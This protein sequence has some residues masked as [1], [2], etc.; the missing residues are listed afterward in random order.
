MEKKDKMDFKPWSAV[1]FSEILEAI[2]N[3]NEIDNGLRKRLVNLLATYYGAEQEEFEEGELSGYVDFE[4][5]FVDVLRKTIR[6]ISADRY[7]ELR[8]K[9]KNILDWMTEELEEE[10][11]L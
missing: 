10:V 8:G 5:E 7:L 11:E 1:L 4:T 9:I 2:P 6:I 3:L